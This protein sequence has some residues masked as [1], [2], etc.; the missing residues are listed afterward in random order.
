MTFFASLNVLD[1]F[2]KKNLSA[3]NFNS[4]DRMSV[5]ENLID[6]QMFPQQLL[7]LTWASGNL[8]KEKISKLQVWYHFNFNI[9]LLSFLCT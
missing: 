2:N 8:Q 7:I 9:G 4:R 5:Q 3:F 6:G 1:G